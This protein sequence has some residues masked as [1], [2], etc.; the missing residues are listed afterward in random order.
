MLYFVINP[1]AKSNYGWF[2]WKKIEKELIRR[3]VPYQ[4][5]VTRRKKEAVLFARKL[6]SGARS[7]T[8]VILGGDGT[9]NEFLN[10]IQR[11]EGIKLG[12][13]PIGSGND[14][15]RG[16]GITKDYKKEIKKM[17]DDPG[18][19][20]IDYGVVTYPSGKEVRFFVSTGMGYDAKVCYEVDHT[21]MKKT[22]NRIRMGRL[23]YLLIGLKD[24]IKSEVFDGTLDIDGKRELEGGG[25]LFA[26]FHVLPFEGGGFRFCPDAQ[27]SDGYMDVCVAKGIA[28]WKMPFI[29]PMAIM[30]K[31][32]KCK[33]V[34][35]Y[36]CKH[37][38]M[39]SKNNQY[40]HTDGEAKKLENEIRLSISKEKIAF[41]N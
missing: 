18:E 21:R 35:Q 33:G 40:V 2:V 29:I 19:T 17:L 15:A 41:I 8:I 11:T 37:A 31:H 30:G 39:S 7:R 34:Y 14:F 25:F 4:Y 23:I 24:L 12:Y 1:K 20:N 36:R 3:K 9:I 22:L 13:I 5:Y 10:G 32:T 28:K 27:A 16:M 6:T 26:S 38:V